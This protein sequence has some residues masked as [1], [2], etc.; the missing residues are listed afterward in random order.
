M[1]Q[2]H[3]IAFTSIASLLFGDFASNSSSPVP[4]FRHHGWVP[5]LEE[6]R[7]EKLLVH[8]GVD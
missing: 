5:N 1:P 4:I 8:R 7:S 2:D 6:Y 3:G